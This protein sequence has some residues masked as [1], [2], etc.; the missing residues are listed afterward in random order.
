ME[1]TMRRST[2]LLAAIAV[3]ASSVS[4]SAFAAPAC[5]DAKGKFI[6]CPAPAAA[7]A[8]MS[9]TAGAKCR[10]VKTKA[11]AKCGTPGTEPVPMAAKK[12]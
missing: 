1:M 3:L 4:A 2:A 7:P 5:R 11:F 8:M 9:M 12:K 10:N 6:K